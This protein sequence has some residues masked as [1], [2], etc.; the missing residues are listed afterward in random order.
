LSWANRRTR[1]G[2]PKYSFAA[3]F[4][5]AARYRVQATRDI[6]SAPSTRIIVHQQFC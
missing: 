6:P 5:F 2:V 1:A 3:R 4:L